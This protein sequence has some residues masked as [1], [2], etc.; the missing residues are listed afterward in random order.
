MLQRIEKLIE[1]DSVA[2]GKVATIREL[3]FMRDNRDS[4]LKQSR[5]LQAEAKKDP[6]KQ[7]QYLNEAM[8]LAVKAQY[9]REA[10]EASGKIIY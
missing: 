4:W 10:I 9:C 8:K 7:T 2:F 6:G 1:K 5:A 3:H